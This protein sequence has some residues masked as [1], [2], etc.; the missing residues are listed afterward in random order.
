MAKTEGDSSRFR[1]SFKAPDAF[2]CQLRLPEVGSICDCSWRLTRPRYW[3]GDG[4]CL[5]DVLALGLPHLLSPVLGQHMMACQPRCQ[6]CIAVASRS[7][8]PPLSPPPA[9]SS[10]TGTW[11]ALI[12]SRNV[13]FM[14]AQTTFRFLHASSRASFGVIRPAAPQAVQ[15]F[16]GAAALDNGGK[17]D[18]WPPRRYTAATLAASKQQ[19]LS[20]VS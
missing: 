11:L 5:Q 6:A 13:D 1:L 10:V 18:I 3:D 16:A 19:H 20:S 15:S 12:S 9:A 14:C 4:G 8:L 7:P 17:H 2:D